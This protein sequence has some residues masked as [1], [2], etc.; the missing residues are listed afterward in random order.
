MR[1]T[2]LG[3]VCAFVLLGCGRNGHYVDRILEDESGDRSDCLE[4]YKA[5]PE[6][7]LASQPG[8]TAGES[9]CQSYDRCRGEQYWP[10]RLHG[11]DCQW[12]NW[13]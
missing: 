13:K 7:R 12:W 9:R 2:Q 4:Q 8:G 3:L 6:T 10:T 5:C 11:A 1:A